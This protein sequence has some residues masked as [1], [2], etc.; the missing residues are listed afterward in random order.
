MP[1]YHFRVHKDGNWNEDPD[2]S[3]LDNDE[4][5]HKEALVIVHNLTKGH[6]S[7][8]KTYTV[9]VTEGDRLVWIIRWP[10]VA[11]AS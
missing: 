8:P 6:E 9:R 5:A 10:P 1:R 2:G 7:D 11:D 3:A 4:A